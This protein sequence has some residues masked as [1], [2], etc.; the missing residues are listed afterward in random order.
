MPCL[1]FGIGARN[2]HSDG[3]GTRTLIFGIGPQL[4]LYDIWPACGHSLSYLRNLR[5]TKIS[6]RIQKLIKAQQTDQPA[7]RSI[8]IVRLASGFSIAGMSHLLLVDQ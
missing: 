1:G 6:A 2:P 4:E 7:Q 3:I 5:T 8:A